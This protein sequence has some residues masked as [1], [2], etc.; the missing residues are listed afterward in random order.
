MCFII[1]N[2]GTTIPRILAIAH[3]SEKCRCKVKSFHQELTD[4]F[5]RKCNIVIFKLDESESQNKHERNKYHLASA[6]IILR[7][8]TIT[9]NIYH[10]NEKI[11]KNSNKSLFYTIEFVEIMQIKLKGYICFLTF[12]QII[13]N[14]GIFSFV[15]QLQVLYGLRLI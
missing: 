8:L 4:C 14:S 6:R 1:S 7:N 13:F 10:K 15:L 2:I 11:L 5:E 3:S 9:I 12:I